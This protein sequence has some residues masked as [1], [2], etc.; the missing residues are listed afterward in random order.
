MKE[1]K[2]GTKVKIKTEKELRD[3]FGREYTYEED[4]DG[5]PQWRKKTDEKYIV[6]MATMF[7]NCGKV[8]TIKST[9]PGYGYYME[10]VI[11]YW[12]PEWFDVIEEVAIEPIEVGNTIV[13][14]S[15]TDVAKDKEALKNMETYKY[16]FGDMTCEEM[17]GKE[18]KVEQ[19]Q[20]KRIAVRKANGALIYFP[21]VWVSNVI[22]KEE[23]Y[24]REI[25]DYVKRHD[26][27]KSLPHED[28]PYD[29]TIQIDKGHHFIK[30]YVVVDG[31]KF[32]VFEGL[33]GTFKVEK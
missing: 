27:N 1:L 29:W 17:W 16:T 28:A 14:K 20:D 26:F 30:A 8:C 33:D 31:F 15:M 10:E 32:E 22:S 12:N 19:V 3:L 2:I 6:F 24:R 9:F 11:C 5:I 23:V 18:Y 4:Y 7:A 13:L 25:E 21:S